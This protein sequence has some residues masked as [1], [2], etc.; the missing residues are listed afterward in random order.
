MAEK[1]RQISKQN[2]LEV[3][4]NLLIDSE[5]KNLVEK[6]IKEFGKID[7]L[8]NSAYISI[9]C[10]ITDSNI[11]ESFEKVMNTNVRSVLLLTSLVVP[12]LEK[13]K[14]CVVNVKSYPGLQPVS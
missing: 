9:P 10:S 14:G 12:Y 6:T 1:C 13:T 4:C 8:I 2:T 3:K 7:I 11:M 5:V